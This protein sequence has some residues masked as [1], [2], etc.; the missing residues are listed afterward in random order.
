MTKKCR[1]VDIR[2]HWTRT[3]SRC[4]CGIVSKWKYSITHRKEEKISL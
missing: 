2:C 1:I 4:P 3:N